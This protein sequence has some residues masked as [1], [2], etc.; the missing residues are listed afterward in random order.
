MPKSIH[1]NGVEIPLDVIVANIYDFMLEAKTMAQLH[2]K[3]DRGEEAL[4]MIVG[5]HISEAFFATSK[6]P[7]GRYESSTD[8][9]HLESSNQQSALASAP[10]TKS[11]LL[12]EVYWDGDLCLV[13]TGEIRD[14]QGEHYLVDGKPYYVNG[15]GSGALPIESVEILRVVHAEELY[16][17]LQAAESEL[18]LLRE[19]QKS[20]EGCE[21]FLDMRKEEHPSRVTLDDLQQNLINEREQSKQQQS[22][23]D[24]LR[25][26]IEAALPMLSDHRRP[27]AIGILQDALDALPPKSEQPAQSASPRCYAASLTTFAG[28][29]DLKLRKSIP[30]VIEE[31]DDAAMATWFDANISM[32]GDNSTEAF[33]GVRSTIVS[34]WEGLH[35]D[36]DR[37]G[38]EPTRQLAVLREFIF[39]SE[40]EFN[41]PAK[42]YLLVPDKAGQWVRRVY[43]GVV[44]FSKTAGPPDADFKQDA[45]IASSIVW[46][47]STAPQSTAR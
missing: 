42:C 38:P 1:L 29:S 5:E 31:N 9:V 20:Y 7:N 26:A 17:R 13:K 8:A 16:E 3:R 11:E 41:V 28:V 34:T 35:R 10:L 12:G 25:A 39:E 33:N 18:G 19:R 46:L 23:I 44:S 27:G 37:L 32:S 45:S 21:A 22:T 24:R 47:A 2:R 14:A 4:R 15:T 40:Q 30:I 43:W 36:I 6:E